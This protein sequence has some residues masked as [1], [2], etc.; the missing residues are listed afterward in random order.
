MTVLVFH[1]YGLSWVELELLFLALG[2]V[3]F[4]LTIF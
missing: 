2:W 3:K 1:C 4:G